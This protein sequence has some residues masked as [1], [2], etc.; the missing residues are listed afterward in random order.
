[1]IV[2]YIRNIGLK[3]TIEKSLFMQDLQTYRV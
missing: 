1:M 3:L 2:L